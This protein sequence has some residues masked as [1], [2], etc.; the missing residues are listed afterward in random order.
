MQK[1]TRRTD[2]GTRGKVGKKSRWIKETVL[3]WGPKRISAEKLGT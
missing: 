2:Q 1:R 3:V